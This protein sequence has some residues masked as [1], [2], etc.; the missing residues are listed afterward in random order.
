VTD[1]NLWLFALESPNAGTAGL[2]RTCD[3]DGANSLLS[4]KRAWKCPRIS[5]TMVTQI[6]HCDYRSCTHA[7]PFVYYL[8]TR[9]LNSEVISRCE[10]KISSRTPLVCQTQKIRNAETPCSKTDGSLARARA[11]NRRTCPIV[12]CPLSCNGEQS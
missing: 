3:G 4:S 6:V 7:A 5:L 10:T 12:S 9:G 2:M 11:K 8:Y 1:E